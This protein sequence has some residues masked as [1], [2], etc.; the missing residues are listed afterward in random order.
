MTM[1]PRVLA[2]VDPDFT[3]SQIILASYLAL[4]NTGMMGV[5]YHVP[6]PSDKY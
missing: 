4:T 2:R 3:L 6:I 1:D 5:M